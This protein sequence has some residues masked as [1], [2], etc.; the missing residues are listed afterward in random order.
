MMAMKRW[1]LNRYA[2]LLLGLIVLS[3]G[4]ETTKKAMH[5]MQPHRLR[6]WNQS[7]APTDDAYFSVRDPISDPVIE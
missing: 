5:E 1:H 7:P 6:R 3:S 4:C 2:P